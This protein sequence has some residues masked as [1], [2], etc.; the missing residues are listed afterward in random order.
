MPAPARPLDE[1]IAFVRARTAPAPVPLV[2]ELVLHQAT[3]LTPLWHATA[4]ELAGWD[5]SPFWAFPWAGGQ[6][7]ARH[8]LDRP[9]RVRGRRVVDFATGSGLVG[10]AAVRAGAA[11]VEAWDV[12]PFCEAAV[13]ANAALNGLALPFRAGDPIGAPLPGVEVLLAGDVFYEGPLAARAL[14]WFRALAGRGVTVLAGDAGRT[15]APREG[16]TV[17]AE[18][19]VP[20]TVEIEDAAVRGARVL[21][22]MG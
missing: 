12:D 15:Y 21:Q 2:P 19:Q 20:T 4:G 7:L 11:E 6:A 16:F 22:I 8:L 17:V 14:A 3:E 9:E 10:L 13:R 5:D 18:F 1:L